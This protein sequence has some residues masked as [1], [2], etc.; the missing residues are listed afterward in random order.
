MAFEGM[1]IDGART[2]V[3]ALTNAPND[4]Q[5]IINGLTNQIHGIDWKGTD[6]EKFVSDWQQ[7]SSSLINVINTALHDAAQHLQSEISQQ[8]QASGS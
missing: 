1:D 4:L 2:V 5:S 6:R 3:S 7:A 8:E